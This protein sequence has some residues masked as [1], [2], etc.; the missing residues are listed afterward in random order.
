MTTKKMDK[1]SMGVSRN[2]FTFHNF[3]D[4]EYNQTERNETPLTKTMEE[5]CTHLHLN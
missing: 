3:V 4:I 5:K 2:V 1:K